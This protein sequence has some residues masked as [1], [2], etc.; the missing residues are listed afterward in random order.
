FSGIAIALMTIPN[1]IGILLLRKEM[2][3]TVAN[4][5][6]TMDFSGKKRRD[7]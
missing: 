6:D 1:I 5:W 3:E 2:K 4:Y 7:G